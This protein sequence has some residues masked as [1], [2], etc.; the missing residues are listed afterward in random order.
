[1]LYNFEFCGELKGAWKLQFIDIC[2]YVSG[3]PVTISVLGQRFQPGPLE[4][5]A[6]ALIARLRYATEFYSHQ[7]KQAR[8]SL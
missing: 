6:G 5:E 4:L 8:Y 7:I 2:L 3:R 1:V